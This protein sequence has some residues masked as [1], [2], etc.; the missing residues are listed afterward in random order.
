MQDGRDLA[1]CSI[2]VYIGPCDDPVLESMAE[3]T[4]A[5]GQLGMEE[6]KEAGPPHLLAYMGLVKGL[7]AKGVASGQLNYDRLKEH[8]EGLEALTTEELNQ[9]VRLCKKAKC[10]DNKKAK[11][12]ICLSSESQVRKNVS[13]AMVQ[14]GFEKKVGRPPA[15]G[16]ERDLA[17][18]LDQL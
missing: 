1:S 10:F 7:V 9:Q 3:Q 2:D 13:E 5:Y 12:L 18:W 16:L 15:S 8:M 11:L 4:K 14:V 6:K 17:E